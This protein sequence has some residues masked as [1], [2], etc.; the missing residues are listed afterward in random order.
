MNE[1]AQ[2]KDKVVENL[3]QDS[4]LAD[5][6]IEVLNNNGVITLTGE[7]PSQELSE[8]AEAIAKHT[9]GAVTVIN[10]IVINSA[11]KRTP[12]HSAFVPPK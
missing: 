1:A 8:A 9:D 10:E 2:L 7:V 5:Y 12:M 3:M 11:A 6:P 4:R